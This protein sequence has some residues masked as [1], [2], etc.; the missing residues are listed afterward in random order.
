[1]SEAKPAER[2]HPPAE[3]PT[4]SPPGSETK[5]DQQVQE[6]AAKEREKSGGY[7]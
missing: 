1:M 2:E 4:Q 5:V 3:R 6:E 7:D